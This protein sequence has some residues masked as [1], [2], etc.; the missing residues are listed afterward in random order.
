MESL[1][2]LFNCFFFVIK[3]M[4]KALFSFIL[5]LLNFSDLPSYGSNSR[6][7]YKLRL[8]WKLTPGLKNHMRNL[9]N[10]RQVVESPK[11]WNSMDY[12]YPKN[13][14][15]QL[16]HCIQSIYLTLLSTTVKIHQTPYVIFETISHFSR[17]NS[18]VFF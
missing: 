5:W 17:H 1:S 14:F 9:D 15:L 3:R 4:L 11:R 2:L 12:I 13:I 8:L 10:F 6:E 16:K 7:R 18:S